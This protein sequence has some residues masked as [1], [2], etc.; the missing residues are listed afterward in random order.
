MAYQ[1]SLSAGQTLIVVQQG[2]QTAVTLTTVQFGQH[3]MQQMSVTTGIWKEPPALFKT[4]A[5]GW[6]LRV[7]IHEE[8][9]FIHI[10][11]NGIRVL[12]ETPLL[13]NV[14]ILKLEQIP[15]PN[16]EPMMPMG[17]RTNVKMNFHRSVH[18]SGRFCPNCGNGIKAKDRF[19]SNCGQSLQQNNS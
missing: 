18:A 16:L 7:G 4:S 8:Q 11:A 5:T 15:D 1:A 3:Q 2:K 6:I 19:C 17:N 12:A 9:Y 10:Q 14:E 13:M